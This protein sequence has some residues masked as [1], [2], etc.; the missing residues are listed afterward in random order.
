MIIYEP[1]RLWATWPGSLGQVG[2]LM[3]GPPY[4]SLLSPG[5]LVPM[6]LNL[7]IVHLQYQTAR[8]WAITSEEGP[9]LG[10]ITMCFIVH[11]TTSKLE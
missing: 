9:E 10:E 2:R 5:D 1:P 8:R 6:V 11:K 3:A 7:V 4:S